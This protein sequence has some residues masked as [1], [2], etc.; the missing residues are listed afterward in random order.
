MIPVKAA[1]DGESL[2]LL[3]PDGKEI[4]AKIIKRQK[5]KSRLERI[6]E[7]PHFA[8]A[9]GQPSGFGAASCSWAVLRF[10]HLTPLQIPFAN[11]LV[12]LEVP[13][14][15]ALIT[16]SNEVIQLVSTAILYRH[17]VIDVEYYIRGLPATVDA[18]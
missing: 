5:G 18:R 4:K 8:N 16:S 14:T 11:Q 7:F 1:I 3:R 9:P 15:V 12:M 2:I 6:R 10:H 13:S 17:L